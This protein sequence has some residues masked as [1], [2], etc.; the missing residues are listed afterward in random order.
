MM[1]KIFILDDKYLFFI[2]IFFL[3][4]SL[5]ELSALTRKNNALQHID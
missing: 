5:N 1:R 3:V 4:T 2:L